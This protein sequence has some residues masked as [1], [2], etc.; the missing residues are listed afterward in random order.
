M[1]LIAWPKGASALLFHFFASWATSI[2]VGAY[3]HYL[4]ESQISDFFYFTR[5]LN[6][7]STHWATLL[8]SKLM[9][10]PDHP[11][12]P[13]YRTYTLFEEWVTPAGQVSPTCFSKCFSF[14]CVLLSCWTTFTPALIQPPGVQFDAQWAVKGFDLSKQVLQVVCLPLSIKQVKLWALDWNWRCQD[15]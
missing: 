15:E 11:T 2:C 14:K 5:Q 12:H 13:T 9:L 8:K 10:W 4:P 3:H 6:I 1:S 7:H